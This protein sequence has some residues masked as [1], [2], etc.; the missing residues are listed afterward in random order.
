MVVDT[1]HASRCCDYGPL[2]C[3]PLRSNAP[4]STHLIILRTH[5]CPINSC[6]VLFFVNPPIGVFTLPG[7]LWV[8]PSLSP[9]SNILGYMEFVWWLLVIGLHLRKFS[10][11]PRWYVTFG[12]FS[13]QKEWWEIFITRRAVGNISYSMS[14]AKT[15]LHEEPWGSFFTIRAMGKLL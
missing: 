12:A 15:F 13:Q 14:G 6:L 2:S 8:V 11:L 7:A 9:L 1:A 5:C 10:R 3:S 4:S